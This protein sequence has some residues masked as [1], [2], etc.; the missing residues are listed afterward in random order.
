MIKQDCG[1]SRNSASLNIRES[2][3][4]SKVIV[5]TFYREVR[6]VSLPVSLGMITLF[7]KDEESYGLFGLYWVRNSELIFKT[8]FIMYFFAVSLFPFYVP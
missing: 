3:L 8:K 4:E 6:P 7:S 2:L 5:K 1:S